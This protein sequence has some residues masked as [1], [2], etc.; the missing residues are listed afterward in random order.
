MDDD[1]AEEIDDIDVDDYDPND[2]DEEEDISVEFE[3]DEIEDYR[4]LESR[5]IKFANQTL[6]ID[7]NDEHHC[8]LFIVPDNE[9]T[10]S[11]I[12]TLEEYT[13]AVGIRATEIENGTPVFTDV[14][15]MICPIEMAKKEILDGKS[16]YKLIREMSAKKG[17]KTVEIW[18]INDMTLPITRRENRQI[19]KNRISELGLGPTPVSPKVETPKTPETPKIKTPET[20]PK[21]P[22]KPVAKPAKKPAKKTATKKVPAKK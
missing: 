8:T 20:S 18:K 22:V 14:S 1:V 4:D 16:P 10:T 21:T 11:Q 2:I 15:G 6:D 17:S 7:L 13:E 19:T 5:S 9:R 3:D 12:M